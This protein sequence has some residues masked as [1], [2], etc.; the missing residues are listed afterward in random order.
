MEDGTP[1]DCCTMRG[2]S[3]TSR[4]GWDK[5]E[6]ECQEL[7]CDGKDSDGRNRWGLSESFPLAQRSGEET[8]LQ[9]R[10]GAFRGA[11]LMRDKRAST[12]C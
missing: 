4:G 6:D 1:G 9:S 7:S 5:K 3:C 2:R 11:N 10:G 8:L 12:Q